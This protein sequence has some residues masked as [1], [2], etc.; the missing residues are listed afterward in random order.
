MKIRRTDDPDVSFVES[1][2]PVTLWA[3]GIVE[4]RVDQRDRKFL[5]TPIYRDGSEGPV[6]DATEA[7]KRFSQE[8][9]D[10]R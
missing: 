8:Y 1:W 7:Y 9:R 2:D 6:A 3:Y 4:W 5:M 10:G